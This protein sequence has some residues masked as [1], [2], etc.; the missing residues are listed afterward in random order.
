MFGV[1]FFEVKYQNVSIVATPFHIKYQVSTSGDISYCQIKCSLLLLYFLICRFHVV[2]C[3][4]E[5]L[6]LNPACRG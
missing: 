1:E 4:G 6:F 3:N 2:Y 5:P